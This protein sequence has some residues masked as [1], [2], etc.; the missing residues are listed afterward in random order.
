MLRLEGI[1]PSIAQRRRILE[2]LLRTAGNLTAVGAE[3]SPALWRALRDVEPLAGRGDGD[4]RALW[5]IST[6]PTR[7]A[8]LGQLFARQLDAEMLYD[9][10]GGLIW[11]S[12]DAGEDAGAAMIR[13]AVGVSGGHAMLIRAPAAVRAAGALFE[14]QDASAAALT[15]RV[16]ESFDPLG[17]L[18]PGRIW[19]GV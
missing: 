6:A 17:V 13:R 5:R 18:N 4:L 14:S 11:L 16:K 12:L 19:A 3:A 1:A 9:W 10:G 2:S 7:G 15:K 8:E